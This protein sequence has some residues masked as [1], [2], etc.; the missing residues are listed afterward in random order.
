[1]SVKADAWRAPL[2]S[3]FA[4]VLCP[5]GSCCHRCSVVPTC[6]F[7]DDNGRSPSCQIFCPCDASGFANWM[8]QN[9][10]LLSIDPF[11]GVALCVFVGG[12]VG[13]FF[14]YGREAVEMFF[15]RLTLGLCR[16]AMLGCIVAA[17]LL[18]S[19]SGAGMCVVARS[20][21]PSAAHNVSLPESC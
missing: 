16:P 2:A 8:F 11:V 1:M 5:L 18:G 7:V 4:F 14:S 12:A 21:L 19:V 3:A 13:S 17:S 6:Q 20:C 15:G 9:T 10:M